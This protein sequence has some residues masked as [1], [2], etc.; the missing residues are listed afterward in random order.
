M[1]IL[2]NIPFEL[3]IEDVLKKVHLEKESP[4]ITEFMPL[5][6]N[7]IKIANPKAA[8]KLVFIDEKAEDSV[9]INGVKLTSEALRK[10]LEN[11][12]RV[13][14]YVA[15]CGRE[16][17]NI[18][19]DKDDF[20]AE[21]WLDAIKEMVLGCTRKYMNDYIKNKYKLNRVSS[22]CPGSAD[23]NVW[24]IQ[25]QKPLFSLLPEVTNTIGVELT[26]SYLMIPNKSVSG[27]IFETDK[28]FHSCQLC[29]REN[30]S[31]RTV[32]FDGQV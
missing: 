5:Y 27:I 2:E 7:A 18:K 17:E 1:N 8:Y 11:V 22:M 6:N 19:I 26:E 13:F 24:P 28:D 4:F 23:A 15:T 20:L 10:N 3:K 30:C 16:F 31:S 9:V 14:V 32:E 12:Q 25:Q 21:Y 29:H